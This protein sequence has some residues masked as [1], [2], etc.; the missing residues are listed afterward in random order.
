VTL[1]GCVY[2]THLMCIGQPAQAL[3]R[4]AKFWLEPIGLAANYGYR[5]HEL[6]EIEQLVREHHAHLLEAWNEH[7]G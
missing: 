2:N 3:A 6:T 5:A 1:L 4:Q 7:L